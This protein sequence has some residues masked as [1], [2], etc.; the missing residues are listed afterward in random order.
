NWLGF[1]FSITS[2]DGVPGTS[3]EEGEL[4]WHRLDQLERLPMWEGDRSFL[5]LVFDKDSRPFHGYM[6]YKDG[7]PVSWQYFR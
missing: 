1:I 7:R 5:P 4:G 6:P 2:F 3:N